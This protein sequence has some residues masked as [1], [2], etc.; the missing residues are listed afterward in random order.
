MRRLAVLTFF[1]LGCSAASE[2]S[3]LALDSSRERTGTDSEADSARP[4]LLASNGAGPNEAGPNDTRPSEVST[5]PR[6]PTSEE[7]ARY[8]WLQPEARVR[9][10]E[11]VFVPPKGFVRE[12]LSDKS[13]EA[14]L[15]GLPL[16]PAGTPVL[17]YAHGLLHKGDD[18]RI[19]AVAE[20]DVSP[21]DIQQCADS[22]IRLH[23]EWKWSEGDKSSI[24]YHFLSGDLAKWPAFAGG[25][26]PIIEGNKVRWAQNGKAA[27]DHV[28]FRKYLDLVFNYASTI[29]VDKMSSVPVERDN[30]RAGD[31]FILPG[32]PGHA[33]LM[34]DIVKNQSGKRMALLGQGYMPAQD[35]QVLRDHSG[36]GSVWFSLDGDNVDT[37]FWPVPFPWSS[38]RRM[39]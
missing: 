26:R 13:F 39:K 17:S 37:P 31:F 32:G 4:K 2:P 23:A 28:A 8:A 24:A 20:L 1:A 6:A 19:G 33:I 25:S 22:V 27:S 30:I 3:P 15:R 36:T 10:L 16:R 35:F 11:D 7:F 9:R 18:P 21:V 5:E 12:K 34:L 38:V 29:S 14:F